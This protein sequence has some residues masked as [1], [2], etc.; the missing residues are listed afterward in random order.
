MAPHKVALQEFE[1]HRH[2][3]SGHI[4][5]RNVA[6]G[7][8]EAPLIQPTRTEADFAQHVAGVVAL[9]PTDG[10]VFVPD[11]LNTHVPEPLVRFVIARDYLQ[12]PPDHLGAKGKPGILKN[13][14][15]RRA[16]MMDGDHSVRLVDIPKYCSWLNQIECWFS[17]FARRLSI[18]GRVS[19]RSKC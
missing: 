5:S 12:I 17:I 3:T 15:S 10:H 7:C 1:D 19:P 11:N 16:F 8:I 6:T 14:A 18:G 4:A 2:G 9:A 13:Q